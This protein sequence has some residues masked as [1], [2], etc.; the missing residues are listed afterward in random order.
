MTR[1][2]AHAKADLLKARGNL[3]IEPKARATPTT[4]FAHPSPSQLERNEGPAQPGF[5]T[6]SRVK[7]AL[8]L[9]SGEDNVK[10]HLRDVNVSRSADLGCRSPADT[11][12]TA[13]GSDRKGDEEA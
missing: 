9:R 2:R 7:S 11:P 10:I 3:P 5:T 8:S 12:F 13:F 4:T 6:L 1:A